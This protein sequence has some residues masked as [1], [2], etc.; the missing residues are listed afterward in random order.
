MRFVRSPTFPFRLDE[1]LPPVTVSRARPTRRALLLGGAAVLAGCT[2]A[3]R[4]ARARPGSDDDA[5]LAAW[6]SEQRL[7]A[8]Y[9]GTTPQHQAHLAHLRALEARLGRTP[10]A[11]PA[12]P[13]ADDAATVPALHAAAIAA[14]D[15][16]NAALLASIAA[17]HAVLGAGR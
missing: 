11:P 16:G 1:R 5:L 6:A 12:P 3:P 8:A 17:S 15:G 10:S 7:L 13:S 9:A 14:R 4:G 2:T